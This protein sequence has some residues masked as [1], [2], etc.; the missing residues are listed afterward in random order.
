MPACVTLA[1]VAASVHSLPQC[2]QQP[3]TSSTLINSHVNPHPGCP[4][5]H[6]QPAQEGCWR[7]RGMGA[8]CRPK[9]KHHL[10]RTCDCTGARPRPYGPPPLP[11]LL[12]PTS[13]SHS[14]CHQLQ[15]SAPIMLIA[16]EKVSGVASDWLRFRYPWHMGSVT[17]LK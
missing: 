14:V 17:H 8:G 11:I 15:P 16:P 4:S 12:P 10:I 3:I 9:K 5:A 7:G 2:I 6:Q 1:S 13:L